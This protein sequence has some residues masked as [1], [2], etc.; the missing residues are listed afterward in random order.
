[1]SAYSACVAFVNGN[2]SKKTAQK[3]W[4]RIPESSKKPKKFRNFLASYA[5]VFRD[6]THQSVGK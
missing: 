1:V 6:E 3:L 4:E 2:R 5:I